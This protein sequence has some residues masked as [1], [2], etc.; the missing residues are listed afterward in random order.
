[1][2]R[3]SVATTT[4]F[5]LLL[6]LAVAVTACAGDT[7]AATVS[8]TSPVA[9]VSGADGDGLVLA[10]GAHFGF[11][12]RVEGGTVTFDPARFLSGDAALEAARAAGAIGEG[13]DLPNDFFIANQTAEDEVTVPVADAAVFTLIGFDETN[14]PLEDVAV[15]YSELAD[16]F[17]APADGRDVMTADGR[18]IYG[19]VAGDL[20]MNMIIEG[21]EVAGGAQQYLP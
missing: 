19:F 20:P 9:S 7:T 12:R 8:P 11:V 17:A 4:A 21:G 16:L 13:E 5:A 2:S 14:S 1:M 6:L 15:T 3:R 18:S 10:D